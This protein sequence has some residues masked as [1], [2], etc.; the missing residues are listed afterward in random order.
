[1]CMKEKKE[2]GAAVTLCNKAINLNKNSYKAYQKRAAIYQ[3]M[4]DYDKA[5]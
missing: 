2:Y 4:R 1:M 5:M 3:S